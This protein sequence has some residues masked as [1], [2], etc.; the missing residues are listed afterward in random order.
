MI[1][2]ITSMSILVVDVLTLE[3]KSAACF[4]EEKVCKI[5]FFAK[6]IIFLAI[7]NSGGKTRNC[8]II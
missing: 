7:F 3:V 5:L 1:F 4:T 8:S 6:S 2:V